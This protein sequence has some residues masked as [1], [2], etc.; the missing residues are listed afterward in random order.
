MSGIKLGWFNAWFGLI[1]IFLFFPSLRFFLDYE[2]FLKHSFSKET[3]N[4]IA[5]EVKRDS[6]E[7]KI[8]TNA[9]TY[10][11]FNK[12]SINAITAKCNSSNCIDIW[13]DKESRI[14][15]DL[16]VD[17]EYIIERSK[18]E[19]VL[20]FIGLLISTCMICLSLFLV[21]KTNGWGTYE[22]MEKH[23]KNTPLR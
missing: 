2:G 21:V 9:G 8:V 11:C 15:V 10:L 14:V 1:W 20:Y 7:M 13:F 19:L 22:L 16:K 12:K 17:E 5:F 6:S 4:Y 3:V 23:M 18:I